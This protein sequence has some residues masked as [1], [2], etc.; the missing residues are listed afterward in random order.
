V[1]QA[2]ARVV[3]VA[4]F[5]IG[6]CAGHG[7]AT[8]GRTFYGWLYGSEVMPERGVEFQQWVYEK[9]N[10][11][12]AHKRETSV[13]WGPLV[14]VTDQLELAL[15]IEFEWTSL[16][17]VG[18]SF[19]LRRFGAEARYRFVTQDPENAPALAPLL[20]VAVKRD[21]AVRDA[22]IVEADLVA[23]YDQGPF[24]A[25][26]DLGIAGSISANDA[27]FE[28]RPGAGFSVKVVGDLRLGAEAFL[29]YNLKDGTGEN[30][31]AVGP[32][33]AWTHGRFW[34]SGAALIGVD[35]INFAPR[36]MFGVAF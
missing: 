14:G 2:F 23:S 26:I 10:L 33:F 13:W 35:N 6:L 36:F 25:L 12:S 3:A 28:A 9:D 17:G 32:N 21:V 29:E 27:L 4:T 7:D 11:G 20:R 16:D 8:A 5:V 19:T 24:Q 18:T 34:L 31:A 22:V 1:R 15:P 30:W